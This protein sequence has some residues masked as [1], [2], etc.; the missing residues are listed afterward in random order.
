V[1]DTESLERATE[2]VTHDPAARV[3]GVEVRPVMDE[4][5]TEM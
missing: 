3:W 5:G 2:I 1:L 4:A